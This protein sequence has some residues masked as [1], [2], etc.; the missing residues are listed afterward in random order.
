MKII[1]AS[2]DPIVFTDESGVLTI[3]TDS[4]EADPDTDTPSEAPTSSASSIALSGLAAASMFSSFANMNSAL[5]VGL[6]VA[7]SLATPAFG[8]GHGCK[9]SLEIEIMMPTGSAVSE[10]FGETDHYLA[11]TVDTVTWGYYGKLCC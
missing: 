5:V 9:P 11:A 6:T 3:S 2:E 7:A 8:A 10:T 4:C 1:S